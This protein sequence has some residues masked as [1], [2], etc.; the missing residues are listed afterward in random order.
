LMGM[1]IPY[2]SKFMGF[3]GKKWVFI[4]V[5]FPFFFSIEQSGQSCQLW[6]SDFLI[7]KVKYWVSNS[8]VNDKLQFN[9]VRRKISVR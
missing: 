9:L 2:G 6:E 3:V 8:T 1:Q 7:A 5:F 4:T